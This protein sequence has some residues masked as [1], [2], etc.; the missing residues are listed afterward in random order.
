MFFA[1]CPRVKKRRVGDPGKLVFDHESNNHNS[2][3][4][5]AVPKIVNFYHK[6]HC[7]QYV[8]DGQKV[9][10]NQSVIEKLEEMA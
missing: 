5:R 4:R 8:A 3:V 1:D 9:H 2:F 6:N 7:D 10:L